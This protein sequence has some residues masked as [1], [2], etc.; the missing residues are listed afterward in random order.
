[1]DL[2]HLHDV[3]LANKPSGV[4]H[5][6]ASCPMCAEGT[7]S[8]AGGGG[9]SKTFTQEE[10]DAAVV[11]ALKPVQAELDAL[12]TQ[13]SQSETETRIA[14]VKTEAET[15]KVALQAQLDTAVLEAE[16]AKKDHADLLAKIEADKVEAEAAA[17][18]EARREER[19]AKVAEVASFPAEYVTA[20]ADRWVA[21]SDEDFE[22][23]TDSW[24]TITAKSDDGQGD[25]LP[26]ATA[27]VASRNGDSPSAIREVLAMRFTGVDP[28]RV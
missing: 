17:A 24:K 18:R 22:S 3:M 13:T 26:A 10:F 2:Q 19:L 16:K 4:E 25:G 7:E 28:R 1:M 8:P 23:L 6:T 5:D 14:A 12:K 20:N 15:E 9:M 21:M 27:M 11:E